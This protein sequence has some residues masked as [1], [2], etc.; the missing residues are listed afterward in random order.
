MFLNVS[1][2]NQQEIIKRRINFK[3]S[4]IMIDRPH[5]LKKMN[6]IFIIIDLQRMIPKLQMKLKEIIDNYRLNVIF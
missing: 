1:L 4:L 6:F 2:L 5:L 3:F